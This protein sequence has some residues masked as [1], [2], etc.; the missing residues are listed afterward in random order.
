MFCI[1]YYNK[2]TTYYNHIAKLALKICKRT[3]ALN[4]GNYF[5]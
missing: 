2:S 5:H 3:L 1:F 4:T